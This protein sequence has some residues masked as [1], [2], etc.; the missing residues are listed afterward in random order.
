MNQLK[1]EIAILLP[2]FLMT[3]FGKKEVNTFKSFTTDFFRCSYPKY[4]CY[5]CNISYC[6]VWKPYPIQVFY[7]YSDTYIVI[8]LLKGHKRIHNPMG[9]FVW[10]QYY[11]D[12]FI[13]RTTWSHCNFIRAV[14]FIAVYSDHMNFV[15]IVVIRSTT[16]QI[17][18]VMVVKRWIAETNSCWWFQSHDTV[19]NFN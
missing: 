5:I 7:H 1:H 13:N 8:N 14:T 6:T 17:T 12:R 2:S 9:S 19:T 18:V 10:S 4:R 3:F 11:N 15:L 16:I